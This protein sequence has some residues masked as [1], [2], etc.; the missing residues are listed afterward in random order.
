MTHEEFLDEFSGLERSCNTIKG[1]FEV[2][3]VVQELAI[4]EY[5]D[6]DPITPQRKLKRVNI[7][8]EMCLLYL[9]TASDDMESS[10]KK[11]IKEFKTMNLTTSKDLKGK[12]SCPAAK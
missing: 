9:D 1:V 10:L 6:D 11:L 4:T 2:L 7:L 12:V 5:V 8:I 3:T